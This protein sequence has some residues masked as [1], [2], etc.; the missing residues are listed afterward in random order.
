M[1]FVPPSTLKIVPNNKRKI[2]GKITAINAVLAASKNVL[3]T[4]YTA[5][6]GHDSSPFLDFHA[7]KSASKIVPSTV[8][9]TPQKQCC[10][11]LEMRAN[12]CTDFL[13]R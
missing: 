1:I 8:D 12:Y 6:Y 5:L 13:T 4:A 11:F 9:S 3:E 7:Q 10:P 2:T